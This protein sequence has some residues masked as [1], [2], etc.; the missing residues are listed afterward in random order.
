MKKAWIFFFA[1]VLFLSPGVFASDSATEN[2]GEL[3]GADRLEEYLPEELEGESLPQGE[4]P[5]FVSSV[6]SYL[7]DRLWDGLFDG[8][9]F[10]LGLMALILTACVLERLKDSLGE[11]DNAP[12]VTYVEL[13]CICGYALSRLLPLVETVV[14]RIGSLSDFMISLLPVTGVL[15]AAGGSPGSASVQ[16]SGLMMAVDVFSVLNHRVLL[17]LVYCLFALSVDSALFPVVPGIHKTLKKAYISGTVFCMTLLITLLSFQTELS[18]SA[19]G[20][21]ARSVK[22]AFSGFIPI[23]GNLL[24]ESAR[25]VG[26]A[27]SYLKNT[28]GIFAV[29]VILWVA[30]VPLAGLVCAKFSLWAASIFARLC[31]CSAVAGFLEEM[32]EILSMVMASLLC[33]GVYFILSMTLFC[34]SPISLPLT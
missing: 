11:S 17:P 14:E 18:K 10:L 33:V 30:A 16:G 1:L 6:L 32:G 9:S 5:S 3:S 15:W 34:K 12:I 19:D 22:F 7:W 26:A 20:L 24:G 31:S 23:V 21:A 8:G 2:L 28:T 4:D 25:T 13:L 29:T 27:V